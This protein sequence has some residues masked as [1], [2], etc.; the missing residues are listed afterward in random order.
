MPLVSNFNGS[1]KP[2]KAVKPRTIPLDTE[3]LPSARARTHGLY[4]KPSFIPLDVEKQNAL[5]DEL[6]NWADA[7]EAISIDE[8]FH[9]KKIAPSRFYRTV[10]TN[11]YLNVC[12][13]YALCAINKRITEALR[14]NQLYL[15]NTVKHYDSQYIEE[16]RLKREAEKDTQ[17]TKIFVEEKIGIPVF[18]NKKGLDGK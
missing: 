12:Y 6:I 9:K 15:M 18:T 5:G 10:Q 14:N 1:R 3:M 2:K 16:T 4:N 7:T 13:E 8:F 17:I 11:E